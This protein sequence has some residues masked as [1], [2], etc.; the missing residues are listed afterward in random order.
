M[1]GA[2]TVSCGEWQKYRL[3]GDKGNTYQL[4]AWI[5]GY[6]SGYNVASEDVDVLASKP[7]SI[8]FY[9]WIDNYCG[10]HPLDIL[11]VAASAL[12]KELTDRAKR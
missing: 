8:A 1:Y 3:S 2:G 6:L 5:D 9:A 10:S 12:R 11:V 4:Q 7:S